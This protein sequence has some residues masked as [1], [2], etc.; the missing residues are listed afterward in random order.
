MKTWVLI[1]G[2]ILSSLGLAGCGTMRGFVGAKGV[3]IEFKEQRPQPTHVS[4][5]TT[6]HDFSQEDKTE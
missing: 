1:V 4:S 3:G 5:D 6:T 2:I